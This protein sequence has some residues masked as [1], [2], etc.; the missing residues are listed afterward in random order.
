MAR[1]LF[2]QI[3]TNEFEK[4]KASCVKEAMLYNH[5]IDRG[6]TLLRTQVTS[7]WELCSVKLMSCEDFGWF[8]APAAKIRYFLRRLNA[9]K[10]AL[11]RFPTLILRVPISVKSNHKSV[12]FFFS[13]QHLNNRLN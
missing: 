6:F 7:L 5:V 13:C 11:F 9:I 4:T 8:D 3:T 10:F 12:Q 2:L 1:E